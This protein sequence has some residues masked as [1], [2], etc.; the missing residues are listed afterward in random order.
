LGACAVSVDGRTMLA[1]APAF[2]DQALVV[3]PVSMETRLIGMKLG[4]LK[5][6]RFFGCITGATPGIAYCVPSEA[7][8]ILCLDLCAVLEN[9]RHLE[10]SLAFKRELAA[11]TSTEGDGEAK[12]DMFNPEKESYFVVDNVASDG[13]LAEA[14]KKALD[15]S[16]GTLA[17]DG[18]VYLCP[19][20]NDQVLRFDTMLHTSTEDLEQAPTDVV[21]NLLNSRLVMGEG[22]GARDPQPII[23]IFSCFFHRTPQH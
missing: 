21:R 20:N 11:K 18:F 15:C 16:F 14:P 5:G 23:D 13:T 10:F 3:D 2:A 17:Q 19:F 12:R 4:H 7:S 1:A 9:K 8:D 6:P 22:A